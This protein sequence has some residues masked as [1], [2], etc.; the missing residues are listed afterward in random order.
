[1]RLGVNQGCQ[2]ASSESLASGDRDARGRHGQKIA[3]D[4]AAQVVLGR[5]TIGGRENVGL[6]PA[7][8]L[9]PDFGGHFAFVNRRA[10][11]A[12]GESGALDGAVVQVEAG[13]A[14]YLP[15][16][17]GAGVKRAVEFQPGRELCRTPPSG[18][19]L[20]RRLGRCRW[21]R[22]ADRTAPGFR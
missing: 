15:M 9:A 8:D 22:F 19:R 11:F 2:I 5:E 20:D 6:A 7:D 4:H 10:E 13:V 14:I 21:G 17:I 16:R 1:M 12:Q 3:V 18:S